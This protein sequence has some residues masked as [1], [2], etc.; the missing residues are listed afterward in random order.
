[1]KMKKSENLPPQKK[2]KKKKYMLYI[3]SAAVFALLLLKF[4]LYAG[5]LKS[6]LYV[7]TVK[8]PKC[9]QNNLINF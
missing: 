1:M 8:K 6:H 7:C 5:T 3:K 9:F 2:K 4:T